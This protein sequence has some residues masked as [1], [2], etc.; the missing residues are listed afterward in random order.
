MASGV[1]CCLQRDGKDRAEDS[2]SL[3]WHETW[4]S[5]DAHQISIVFWRGSDVER[6]HLWSEKTWCTFWESCRRKLDTHF[7]VR[8]HNDFYCI[9]CNFDNFRLRRYFQWYKVNIGELSLM[10]YCSLQRSPFLEN[11]MVCCLPSEPPGAEKRLWLAKLGKKGSEAQRGMETGICF[12]NRK[13]DSDGPWYGYVWKW[14][15]PP[16]IAI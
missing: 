3:R 11:R 12:A 4:K 6:N 8:I 13:S 10:E 14:G 5:W 15:I 16:I 2:W 9:P 1:A 7:S